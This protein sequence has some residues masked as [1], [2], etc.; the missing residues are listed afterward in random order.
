[1]TMNFFDVA[2]VKNSI[3]SDTK[4]IF[5]ADVFVEEYAGG[6]ELTTEALVRSSPYKVQKLRA[7]DVTKTLVEQNKDKIWIFGNMVSL[8]PAVVPMIM[9]TCDYV[10]LEYDYKFCAHRSIEKHANVE[11]KTCDC[12]QKPIGDL[13][14]SFYYNAKCI[15]WMSEKQ[16]EI[17]LE[18]FPS[19]E[20]TEQYVLSS[21]FDESF[22]ATLKDLREKHKNA[23]RTDW[24]VFKSD[25]WIKGSDAAVDYCKKNSLPYK[26]I[27]KLPYEE[28]LEQ[29]ATAKGLVFLPPGGDTCPRMVIEAKL[30]G[31]ELVINDRVQHASEIWFN[32]DNTQEIEEY[33]YGAREL[34]WNFVKFEVA[35]KV[36]S[37]SGYTTTYNCVSQKYPFEQCIRSMLGFCDEVVVVDGGSTDGTKE[38]LSQ[39]AQ[40]NSQLKIVARNCDWSDSRFAVL[41]G[42]Q[43]AF[44]RSHCTGDFCWQ[45][46]SDE[47]VHEDDYA[48]VRDLMTRFPRGV[49]LVSLPVVEYWGS[50]EKVRMDITP[51]KWRM[52]RN[53]RSITH[54][55]PVQFRKIDSEGKMYASEGTD[56]CDMINSRTGES[57]PFIGFY[58]NEAHEARSMALTGN[59]EALDAYTTWFQ[60]VV[61]GLPS[62]HHFSWFDIERKIKTYK[63]YWGKHWQ[64]LYDKSVEDTAENNMFFDLPW[65]DVND[66]K[67]E[68]LAEKLK[69]N[70]GGWIWHRK[71]TGQNTPSMKLRVGMPALAKQFYDGR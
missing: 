65:K 48:K 63:N 57:I 6:A 30:L 39:L 42:A 53:I 9:G 35:E 49:N 64:S 5:V 27:S 25:S 55:I 59:K 13:I 51:W 66:A 26:E 61:D 18:R 31:C 33:L 37:L 8:S 43:K 1:M 67:I 70:C 50:S 69:N 44:A 7:R 19:L 21:V 14:S 34:F 38:I 41:D 24:L 36:L 22:F 71:W 32:T 52:S 40:E 60:S 10:V 28:M 56:G 47:I 45:M 3:D 29:M 46:D 2:Q 4:I 12:H 62:V 54:G 17:Y 23:T 68:D 15:F 58:T 16:Q 11:G 20:D